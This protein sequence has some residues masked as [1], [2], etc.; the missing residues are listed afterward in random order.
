MAVALTWRWSRILSWRR[1]GQFCSVFGRIGLVPDV[2]G[3]YLLPRIV[4]LQ[5]AK[6]LMFTARSFGP[7]EAKEM[8][9][10]YEI[11]PEDVLMERAMELR[12]V[13]GMRRVRRLG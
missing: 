7:E 2:G 3:F 13:S 10:V 11:H 1:R 6:D 9:I 12:A 5:R 8:G 4:G